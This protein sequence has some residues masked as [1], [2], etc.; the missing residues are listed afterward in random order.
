MLLPVVSSAQESQPGSPEEPKRLLWIIPN[1]RTSPPLK[2]YKPLTT[3][4]KYKLA[5]DDALDPGTFALGAI[6]AAQ[7]QWA[8]TTPA[9][10]HGASAYA[11]YFAASTTDFIVGDLMT[12]AVFPGILHQDPRY[13]RKGSGGGWSRVGYAIGQIVWTHTDARGMQVNYS[14]IL[15]NA[16]AV[17][18][19]NAYYPDSRTL[20][21]NV[22]KLSIQ[23]GVD[24]ISNILKEFSPDLERAF[25]RSRPAQPRSVSEQK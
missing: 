4:E 19:S 15:G 18:I 5:F 23:L 1:Y 21:N 7:A 13:F 2:D 12:E 8:G 14:E 10:G 6:F 22:A 25:S 9:F 3:K 24:A 20:S 17:G 11:R 16:T